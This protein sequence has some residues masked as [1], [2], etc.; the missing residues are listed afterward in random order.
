MAPKELITVDLLVIVSVTV[1]YREI[2]EVGHPGPGVGEGRMDGSVPL[3]STLGQDLV[4]DQQADSD[5]KLSSAPR[6][7]LSRLMQI[8]ENAQVAMVFVPYAARHYGRGQVDH[9]CQ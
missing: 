4:T 3:F 6:F 1:H 7:K 9:A 2:G 8:Q 5:P